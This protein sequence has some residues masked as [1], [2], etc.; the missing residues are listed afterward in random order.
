MLS[1]TE[2]SVRCRLSGTVFSWDLGNQGQ[3]KGGDAMDANVVLILLLVMS[4]LR[5]R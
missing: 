4:I 3:E 2:F 5:D 1:S